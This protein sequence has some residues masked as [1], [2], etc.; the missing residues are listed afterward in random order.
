MFRVTNI[1]TFVSDD[2]GAICFFQELNV[3]DFFSDINE[4]STYNLV[5]FCVYDYLSYASGLIDITHNEEHNFI[6][7]GVK[8]Q[9]FGYL[10]FSINYI[11]FK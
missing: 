4:C 5:E 2:F 6:L 10:K 3:L 1:E 9:E 7:V 8:S 11:P